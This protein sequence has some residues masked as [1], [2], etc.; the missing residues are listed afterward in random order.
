[1]AKGDG[2]LQKRMQKMNLPGRDMHRDKLCPPAPG[3]ITWVL[4]ESGESSKYWPGAG[5]QTSPDILLQTC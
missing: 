2:F 1:M 5:I 4:G 3:S